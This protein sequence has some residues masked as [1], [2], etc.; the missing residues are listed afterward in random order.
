MKCFVIS[1]VCALSAIA[2]L[3]DVTAVTLAQRAQDPLVLPFYE[4]EVRATF[5]TADE[6]RSASCSA[7]ALPD[8]A[9]LAFSCR[10]DDTTPAHLMKGEMMCRAGVKGSFYFVGSS[11]GDFLEEGGRSLMAMGHSIGN[12]MLHH[13]FFME[14]NLNWAFRDI[15]LNRI[16]LETNLQH[17]VNSFVAP[18]GWRQDR[19]DPEHERMLA[20]CLV[21]SGH[22]LSRD[23]PQPWTDM[24]MAEWMPSWR[25][26][27]DD[28]HPDRGRFVS[29][30]EKMVC[31]AESH[32]L[33]PCVTFGTH[34]WCDEK[35]LARQESW[36]KELCRR[37]DWCQLNDWEYGA[38]RYQ[39]VHGRIERIGV[40]GRTVRF[41]IRRFRP[42]ALGDRIPLSLKFSSA[43]QRVMMAGAE[44]SR[45]GR[46]TWT[47]PH[48]PDHREIARFACAND[49]GETPAFPG[50]RLLVLPNEE[51]G[52]LSVRIE[53]ASSNTLCR[54]SLA[55]A[56]PPAWTVRRVAASAEELAPG[57]V[58]ERTF[59]LGERRR[60]DYGFGVAVYPVSVDF[61]NGDAAFRLWAWK[62]TS[63]KEPARDL[64]CAGVRVWRPKASAIADSDLVAWSK[65]GA[66]L[67]DPRGWKRP[68][69]SSE[70]LW[71]QVCPKT[72][73]RDAEL[74]SGQDV[75]RLFVYDFKA[76]KG[77]VVQMKVDL[78][79]DCGNLGLAVNGE[80]IP[81]VGRSCEIPVRQGENRLIL[82]ADGCVRGNYSD[83][84]RLAVVGDCM[85]NPFLQ[86]AFLGE[87]DE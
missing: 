61:E 42:S 33:A 59:G 36:L 72:R 35:G 49:Q 52:V 4:Q 85:D 2:G 21:A 9:R 38:Y 43:P 79:S 34:S 25:F 19:I 44:L 54:V 87:R 23:N 75:A 64:P 15:V 11:R 57:E 74:A 7:A 31:A 24:G 66:E 18:Y 65:A 78:E 56:I 77:G 14:R 73:L 70:A 5:A 48:D 68:G 60:V 86:K 30:L 76:R 1:T 39:A 55:A 17:C 10:W 22:F 51:T 26:S 37:P 8:D 29:G 47:L 40:D 28:R 3:G 20:R 62:E 83:E 16:L 46:G 13:V 82:R 80:K 27:A 41:R 50:L 45:G 69:V 58:F 53:N 67:P 71:Y 12:H 84:V 63:R 6:A 81:F 32:P